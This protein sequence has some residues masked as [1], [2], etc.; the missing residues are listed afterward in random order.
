[1]VSEKAIL[2]NIEKCS[3]K[4]KPFMYNVKKWSSF[5]ILCGVNT[6]RF[7]KHV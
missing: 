1:M 4:L 6:F 5:E 3:K 7:L 2:K